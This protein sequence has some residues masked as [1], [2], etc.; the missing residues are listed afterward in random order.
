MY[1]V[2][3]A[4][5]IVIK[6]WIMYHPGDIILRILSNGSTQTIQIYSYGNIG[7]NESKSINPIILVK[8]Y[9]LSISSYYN[10]NVY[11]LT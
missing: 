8:K 5:F 9:I 2:C 3:V 1:I 6:H 11:I 4:E 10:P 7:L